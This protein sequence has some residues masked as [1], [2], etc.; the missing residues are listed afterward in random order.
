MSN[1]IKV[2]VFIECMFP[3][4]PLALVEYDVEAED[5]KLD[6]SA[7]F[8]GSTMSP[9]TERPYKCDRCDKTYKYQKHWS[10]HVR[11]ECDLNL[12]S[13]PR[14][15]CAFCSRI[16]KRK[17]HVL[18]HIKKVH[19]EQSFKCL[20]F[21]SR[22]YQMLEDPLG[23]F[24]MYVETP[25]LTDQLKIELDEEDTSFAQFR[26]TATLAAVTFS[27]KQPHA[28]LRCGKSYKH[29]SHLIQHEKYEC[30]KPPRFGCF[31]CTYRSDELQNMRDPL[32]L[33]D[34]LSS[35]SLA[36]EP[37]SPDYDPLDPHNTP[38]RQYVCHYCSR[39]YKYKSHLVGHQKHE[40]QKPPRFVCTYCHCKSKRKGNMKR[41]LIKVHKV[42]FPDI[43]R[44]IDKSC[45]Q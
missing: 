13:G 35:T 1:L 2:K 40:C 16:F 19:L 3:D 37:S 27:P 12:V 26:D 24:G 5:T 11:F 22:R 14:F 42:T 25:A 39:S 23:M 36:D 15:S 10:R 29:S 31:Y 7:E 33:D 8:C 17:E 6:I 30:H 20:V 34:E 4:D 21:I 9:A 41:H 28:C 44:Y 38:L 18:R 32:S 43:D 45:R